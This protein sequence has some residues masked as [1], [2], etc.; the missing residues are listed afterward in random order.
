MASI[1]TFPVVLYNRDTGPVRFGPWTGPDRGNAMTLGLLLLGI[2]LLVVGLAGLLLPAVPGMPLLFAGAVA[3]AAADGFERVGWLTLVVIALLAAAGTGVDHAAS[4]L[5]ARKA[6]ASGWGLAGAV[7][8]LVVGIPFGLPGIVLGPG[9]GAVALEYARDQEFRRA[10]KA[11]TG[12][13]IG[14]LVGTVLKYAIAGILIGTL[15]LAYWV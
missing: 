3:I 10:A 15:L 9:I 2:V 8:G 4:L 11:G 13:F 14:F 7:I 12:V 6:G 5:G 1:E